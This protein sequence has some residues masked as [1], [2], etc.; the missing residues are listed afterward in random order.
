[1]TQPNN[2]TE[3]MDAET[4]ESESAPR[5]SDCYTD[6][7]FSSFYRDVY[8]GESKAPPHGWIQWKGTDVCMDVHCECGHHAHVDAE[9]FYYF[10][11]AG[12]GK[13]YAVGQVVQMIP[14]TDGQAKYAAT[15]HSFITGY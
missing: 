12:C 10:E 7:D 6:D 3:A 1:M 5:S 11:C 2:Q 14:L 8:G 4:R 15:R 13:R 9:F